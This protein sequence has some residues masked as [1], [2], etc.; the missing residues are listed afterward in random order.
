MITYIG[1]IGVLFQGAVIGLASFIVYE[2]AQIKLDEWVRS[3]NQPKSEAAAKTPQ[4]LTFEEINKQ[5]KVNGG[6]CE[7]VMKDG[8]RATVYDKPP[9]K[10]KMKTDPYEGEI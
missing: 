8:T 5:I 1:I 6:Y 10:P 4:E 7:F 9:G 3:R 2:V